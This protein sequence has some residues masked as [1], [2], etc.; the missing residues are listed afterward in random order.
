VQLL[1]LLLQKKQQP[2]EPLPLHVL[3]LA[4]QAA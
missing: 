2:C 3:L 1:V 4:L